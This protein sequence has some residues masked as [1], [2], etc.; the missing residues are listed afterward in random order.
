[1]SEIQW[2]EIDISTRAS[3]R[4]EIEIKLL[5][6]PERRAGHTGMKRCIRKAWQRRQVTQGDVSRA[7]AS[8]THMSGW[9][10]ASAE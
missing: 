6:A 3:C 2:G 9:R 10:E 4:P 1:M 7:L 8:S 5:L